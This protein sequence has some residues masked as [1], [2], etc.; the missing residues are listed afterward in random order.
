MKIAQIP[1]GI[2]ALCAML[3]AAQN[4]GEQPAANITAKEIIAHLAE[5]NHKRQQ[6]LQAYTGR[7]EYHLLYT[8]IG[9]R[10]EATLVVDVNY[11]FPDRKDFTIV[12][13]S[14][15]HWIVNHV[16][17][18]IL[19]TEKEAADPGT[20]ASTALTEE[21]Y[22]VE[23]LGKED[24][25]GR[26]AYIL[27]VEPKTANRLLYRG[28]IWIDAAD[29]ALCKIDGE[30]AKRQSMWISKVVVHHSYRKI[31]DFWLPVKNESN[32]EVRLGGHAIL[33]I[34][35]R[36]YKVVAGN[37]SSDSRISAEQSTLKIGALPVDGLAFGK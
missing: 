22:E 1:F 4:Q 7:R 31:G 34:D 28:K 33:S 8:G 30:P 3:S 13:E 29:Y 35:Y 5:N 12:S 32:T 11:K 17:K 24:V 36:D 14:G 16:F 23:L 37:K 15:S 21:N 19:D 26:R 25:N 2:I 27:A 20:Q 9:G 6:K 18:K 10:R